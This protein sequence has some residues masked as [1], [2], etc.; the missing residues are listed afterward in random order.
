MSARIRWILGLAIIAAIASVGSANAH[1]QGMTMGQGGMPMMM[2]QGGMP[3][4]MGQMPMMMGQMPMMPMMPMMGHGGM[5]MMMGPM[6]MAGFGTVDANGDGVIEADEAAEHAETAFDF[7]DQD[8]DERLLPEEFAHGMPGSAKSERRAKRFAAMDA[9]GDG[10]V[11]FA[12]F[13]TA[14]ASMQAKAD[15]D[16]DGKVTVWE[17]R[18]ARRL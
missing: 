13:M 9:D 10:A 11:N 8:G 17:Y 3:M 1:G 16:G 18:I 6:G 5:P 12:E 2:G 4:M 14:H 15:G 7:F